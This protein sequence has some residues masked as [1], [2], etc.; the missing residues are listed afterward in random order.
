MDSFITNISVDVYAF[1]SFH[2]MHTG[3]HKNEGLFGFKTMTF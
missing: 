2:C 1:L 3:Q